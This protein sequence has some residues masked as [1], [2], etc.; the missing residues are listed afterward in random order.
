MDK[1]SCVEEQC[2]CIVPF[3]LSCECCENCECD[4]EDC[5]ICGNETLDKEE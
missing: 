1:H 2:S 4:C 5:E 3:F